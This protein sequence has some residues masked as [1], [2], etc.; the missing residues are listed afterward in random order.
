MTVEDAKPFED[1]PSKSHFQGLAKRGWGGLTAVRLLFVGHTW[2]WVK[3]TRYP[4]NP[5]VSVSGAMKNITKKLCSPLVFFCFFH[6]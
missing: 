4:K 3:T 1:R 2:P 6:P 5:R